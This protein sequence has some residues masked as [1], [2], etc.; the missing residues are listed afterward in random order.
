MDKLE[1]QELYKQGFSSRAI[2]EK[3]GCSKN[4]ILRSLKNSGIERRTTQVTSR[5]YCFDETVFDTITEESAY[6]I[7]FLMA[8]GSIN[9]KNGGAAS[10]QISLQ[11]R[12]RFQLEKFKNFLKS[13]HPIFEYKN[14][15]ISHFGIRSNRLVNKLSEYGVVPRKSFI[16][17]PPNCIEFNRHFWRGIIDGDG[18]VSER[19]KYATIN[20][21]GSLEIIKGFIAYV[22]F[23]GIGTNS[24]PIKTRNV[25]CINFVAKSARLIIQNLYD[26][27]NISLERKQIKANEIISKHIEN[28]VPANK[29]RCSKCKLC[30]PLASFHKDRGAKCGLQST[31]KICRKKV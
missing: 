9:D 15:E 25:W 2:G 24:V 27:A 23:I 13:E 8:D 4:T 6:W 21:T 5:I 1:I 30:F 22:K 31:C 28:L 17:S 3:L 19:S 11:R 16:A 20:L 14:K 12:D 7:G 10:I 18:S 29:K 26:K